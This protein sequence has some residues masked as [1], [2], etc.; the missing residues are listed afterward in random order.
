MDEI[1]KPLIL[2]EKKFDNYLVSN[3]GK[4]YN[5][6]LK[7][8]L[9]HTYYRDFR[10]YHIQ[11]DNKNYTV[12]LHRVVAEL[13]VSKETGSKYVLFKDNNREN[14][15]ADN[16]YWSDYKVAKT[17]EERLQKI[18]EKN[19]RNV[20]KRRQ[21]IK[22]RAVLYKGG[23]CLICGYN[24][25]VSALDFHHLNPNEKDF[26]ISN[27]YTKNWESIKLELDKCV[28]LCANCHRE[29]ESNYLLLDLE[30]LEKSRILNIPQ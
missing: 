13:F 3:T 27:M 21:R 10:V 6:K 9:K 15:N 22:E 20:V 7:K 16:L 25:C 23:A 11:V 18:R 1:W 26:G 28:L 4:V 14:C 12:V 2:N 29:I 19:K 5:M 8:E 17:D 24:R 30:Q